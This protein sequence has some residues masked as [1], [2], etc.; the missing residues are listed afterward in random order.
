MVLKVPYMIDLGTCA[1]IIDCIQYKIQGE[2]INWKI[3]NRP[4]LLI[5]TP[6]HVKSTQC[7][8]VYSG[9]LLL[10]L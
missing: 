5:A 10:S 4:F 3:Q 2:E 1:K 8:V 7:I 9:N 6:G